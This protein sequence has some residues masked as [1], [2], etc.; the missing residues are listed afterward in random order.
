MK[1]SI[2]F[3]GLGVALLL[4]VSSSAF[5][6]TATVQLSGQR[7]VIRGFGGMHHPG[8]QGNLAMNAAQAKLAFGNGPRQIGLNILRIPV[9]ENRNAWVNSV[10]IAKEAIAQGAIVFAAPWNPPIVNN[11]RNAW[12]VQNGTTPAPESK[13]RMF[14]REDRY[15][16]YADYLNEFYDYMKSQGVELYS[17]SIQ[18]EPDW[19]HDWTWWTGAQMVKFLKEQGPRLKFR[20]MAPESFGFNT[21][22]A[23]Y[24]PVNYPV[25][26]DAGAWAQIDVFA[27]H[28]Y[29]TPTA[30]M[31]WPALKQN[32]GDKEMWMT[33]VYTDSRPDGTA[34]EA[35]GGETPADWADRWPRAL[36]V[37]R[38]IHD[39]FV[40]GEFEAYVWWYAVRNYSFIFPQT[41]TVTKRGWCVA[42]FS[43]FVR[44]GYR[45]VEV[46]ERPIAGQDV[47]VSAYAGDS[48]IAVVL[49]NQTDASQQVTVAIPGTALDSFERFTT[50]ATKS[51]VNEAQVTFSGGSMTVT[52][53][54]QSVTTLSGEG[55]KE[56]VE[57]CPGNAERA[58]GGAPARIPGTVEAENFD[59]GG[60]WDS[61][62]TNEGG[63]YR[64][65]VAVDIKAL[66]DGGH[67]VGWM[68][69]GEWL[70]YTV[71]VPTS[72]DYLVTFTSGSVHEGRSLNLSVC[73]HAAGSITVP[74]VAEWGRFGTVSTTLTLSAGLQ[75]I[76]LTV[77]EGDYLDLDSMSFEFLGEESGSGGGG[78]G[79]LPGGGGGNDPTN[80]DRETDD[81]GGG[82]S[83]EASGCGCHQVG[84]V[85]P[86][87]S[88]AWGSLAFLSAFFRFRRSRSRQRGVTG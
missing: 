51:F 69:S 78:A 63:A 72:G 54:P 48:N 12:R 1:S 85:Q 37:A 41:E 74:Q 26:N 34:G 66:E 42:H 40:T 32:I 67:A 77:G 58:Y 47:F 21:Q 53:E 87:G 88:L 73:G 46:T 14:L 20:V 56:P 4:S 30:N 55:P 29:G 39:I 3:S 84:T 57:S 35:T 79:V 13:P 27:T 16:D 25:L 2:R 44:P 36:R 6:Q 86:L 8:W 22:N 81:S 52:L 70:E 7:Q 71:D 49:V 31:N 18:N 38:Q 15:V 45:R 59:E 61:T 50:S 62:L 64:A 80:P 76:R 75:V 82:S 19:G 23:G 60:Y 11:D 28:M 24:N 43:K 33:E 68:T 17:I 83:D 10:A 9:D 65:D 5:A